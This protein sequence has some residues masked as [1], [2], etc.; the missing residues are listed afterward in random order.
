MYCFE[1]AENFLARGVKILEKMH[2]FVENS[3]QTQTSVN[4]P[5]VDSASELYK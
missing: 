2:L 1:G 5:V 3:Q 4:F